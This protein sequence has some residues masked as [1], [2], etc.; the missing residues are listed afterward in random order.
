M[1]SDEIYKLIHLFGVIMIFVSVGGIMLYALNG[2]T[3]ADN[4]L[5]KT[6]A[7]THGI[8]LVFV[9]VAGFGLL[10]RKNIGWEGWVF[11]KLFIWIVLG[12]VTGLI[13]KLGTRGQWLWYVV[14]LL[15]VIAVYMVLF[16]PF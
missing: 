13:Y 15:G 5:G 14:I 9:L 3:K 16:R 4:T 1:L 11:V 6:A 7:I 10:A 2:G 12:G 8:G